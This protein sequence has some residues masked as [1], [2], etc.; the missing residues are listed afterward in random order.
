L[1]QIVAGVATLEPDEPVLT[2]AL[3]LAE[4][5]GATLHLVHGFELP[6]IAWERYGRLGYLEGPSP[7]TLADSLREQFAR[8]VRSRSPDVSVEYH[9]VPGRGG[10]AVLEVA[11]EV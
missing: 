4:R 8:V 1:R 3:E 2:S 7:E 11:E 9:M 10:T 5:S 6:S